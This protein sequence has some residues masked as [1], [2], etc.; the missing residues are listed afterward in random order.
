MGI[1]A[2]V[3]LLF[4]EK[5]G[6]ATAIVF[7]IMGF[8]LLLKDRVK[9]LRLLGLIGLELYENDNKFDEDDTVEKI[10]RKGYING[11]SSGQES[12]QKNN[13]PKGTDRD[14]QNSKP[15]S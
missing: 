2:P 11:V 6:I 9:N 8:V 3:C 12:K 4:Q 10:A 13:L 5:F 14:Q 7:F 15:N 1:A